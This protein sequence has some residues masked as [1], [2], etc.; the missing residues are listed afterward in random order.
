MEEV[1]PVLSPPSR[2]L[3]SPLSLFLF[4]PL[5]LPLALTLFAVLFKDLTFNLRPGAI[6]GIVGPN[7][8]L[9]KISIKLFGNSSPL[10]PKGRGRRLFCEFCLGKWKPMKVRTFVISFSYSSSD[11]L[12]AGN[13]KMG[14]S[15]EPGYV[16]QSRASLNDDRTVHEEISNGVNEIDMGGGQMINSRLYTACFHFRGTDQNKMIRHLSGGE[17]NR[18][19]V[20]KMLNQGM[21]E[22]E[23]GRKIF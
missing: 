2:L 18:V 9:E 23:F 11:N 21:M 3:S 17:R 6:V 7:G 13:I 12:G 5:P 10:H 4:S 22:K 15:V 16:S 1:L 20:A 19:H 14:E 8:E